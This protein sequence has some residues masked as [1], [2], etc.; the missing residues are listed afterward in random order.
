MSRSVPL[1]SFKR[2]YY[3]LFTFTC[4]PDFKFAALFLWITFLFANLSIMLNTEGINL[5]ASAFASTSRS[6]RI[7]L[8]VVLCWYLL[9]SLVASFDLIHFNADL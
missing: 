5:V 9:R 2:L 6:P 1:T 7:A 4:K 8:R 3:R